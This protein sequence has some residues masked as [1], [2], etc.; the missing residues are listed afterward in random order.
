MRLSIILL[1]IFLVSNLLSVISGLLSSSLEQS[2]WRRL[3]TVFK[4]ISIVT[5]TIFAIYMIMVIVVKKKKKGGNLF[6]H[7]IC[8]ISSK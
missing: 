2:G 8:Y 3:S 6:W 5:L 1:S 7:S 4:W